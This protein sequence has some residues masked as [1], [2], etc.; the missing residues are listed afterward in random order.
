MADPLCL[1]GENGNPYLGGKGHGSSPAG[2]PAGLP[3]VSL[4]FST[5]LLSHKLVSHGTLAATILP[6]QFA[7]ETE[8][9]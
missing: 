1:G 8:T 2:R 7:L 5:T 3:T 4:P 6:D 9:G